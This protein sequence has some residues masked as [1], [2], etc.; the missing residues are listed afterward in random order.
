MLAYEMNPAQCKHMV[1]LCIYIWNVGPCSLQIY[2]IVN[3][4][5]YGLQGQ[6]GVCV[7]VCVCNKVNVIYVWAPERGEKASPP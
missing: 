5:K 1:W 6:L 7:C 4:M 3:E 2:H